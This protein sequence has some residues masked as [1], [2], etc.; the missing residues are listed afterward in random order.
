MVVVMKTIDSKSVSIIVP[1]YN[2]EKYI[3]CCLQSLIRQTY[4]NIRV[5]IINDGSTDRSGQ[6]CDMFAQ[7]HENIK[8]FH[9]VNGGVSAARNMGIEQADSDYI[10]FVDADDY[11]E[12]ETISR[13]VT[14]IEDTDSDIAGCHYHT[15]SDSSLEQMAEQEE[16]Y[17]VEVLSGEEFIEKGILSSDTR[18]W[19][20]LY[21]KQI[22]G[23]HRFDTSM[24]IGEDMLFLLTLAR[25]G[26]RFC[27]TS[28]KGYGYYINE[29]GAMNRS[30][31]DSY[32][33]QIRCWNQAAVQI[34]ESMPDLE[35]KV[36]SILM[37]SI[38]LVVGKLA[39]L[40]SVER[41]K[42]KKYINGC[43]EQLKACGKIQGA[44]QALPTGYKI[45][46]TV[47]KMCPSLYLWGYHR[48]KTRK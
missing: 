24:S 48:L 38:M 20:K 27:R 44:Y 14:L 26:A 5:I 33:D 9:I 47:Y 42:Y 35:P 15:F 2:G 10:T 1:V 32:M 36:V 34:A 41:K 4:K 40:K 46:V 45:K 13:L 6:I 39:L 7:Q 18:C 28:Y 23:D 31:K 11:L 37:I 12:A 43:L 19:S 8:V 21:S 3:A 16:Q 30:F 22:I 29:S 17:T 25:N